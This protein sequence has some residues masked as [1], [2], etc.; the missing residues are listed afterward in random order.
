MDMDLTMHLDVVLGRIIML[1]KKAI[2]ISALIPEKIK[3]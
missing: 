2:T 1:Y 3:R